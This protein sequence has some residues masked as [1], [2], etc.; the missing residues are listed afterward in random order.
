MYTIYYV[1][2]KIFSY[3]NFTWPVVTSEVLRAKPVIKSDREENFVNI[4]DS[5]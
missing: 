3:L 5:R 4:G 1:L 2:L